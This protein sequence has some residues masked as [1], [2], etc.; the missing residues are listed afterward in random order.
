MGLELLI[1]KRSR[2]NNVYDDNNL[3]TFTS[4][5]TAHTSRSVQHDILFS[6]SPKQL[7]CFLW[8]CF[9]VSGIVVV[10]VTSEC[11]IWID[12]LQPGNGA[13]PETLEVR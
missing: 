7:H 3:L 1:C 13:S 2:R 5:V 6:Q 4:R 10:A 8:I 12:L 11:K 9:D